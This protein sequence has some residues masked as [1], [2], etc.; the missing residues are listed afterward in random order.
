MRTPTLGAAVLSILAFALCTPIP[1]QALDGNDATTIDATQSDTSDEEPTADPDIV[2][3]GQT[4]VSTE[5]DTTTTITLNAKY[6]GANLV[7]VVDAN[8]GVR[9]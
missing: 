9:Q 7:A 6:S 3:S 5:G 2:L 4:D 8:V 1:A